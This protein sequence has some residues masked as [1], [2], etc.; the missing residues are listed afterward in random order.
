LTQV[1]T[2]ALWISIIGGTAGV[3]LSIFAIIFAI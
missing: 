2:V 1:E 3:A